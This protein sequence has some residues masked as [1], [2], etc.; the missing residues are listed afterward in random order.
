MTASDM[1]KSAVG[2]AG[3]SAMLLATASRDLSGIDGAFGLSAAEW[4]IVCYVAGAALA[5]IGAVFARGDR[6]AVGE[7]E[8]QFR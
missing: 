2:L 5:V 3:I 1:N 4:T 6:K 7:Q 8:H